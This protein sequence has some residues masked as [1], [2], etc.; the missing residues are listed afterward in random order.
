M[1]S[2]MGHVRGGGLFGNL[3]GGQGGGLANVF[4]GM[5]GY[6]GGGGR[7]FLGGDMGRAIAG[8]Q[9]HTVEGSADLNIAFRNA[10]KGMNTAASIA[11]LFK[12]VNIS[13]GHSKPWAEG[14]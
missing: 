6:G 11:G 3:M 5:L 1:G 14:S 10:P 8:A 9:K 13:T 2:V 4:A 12:S 7:G